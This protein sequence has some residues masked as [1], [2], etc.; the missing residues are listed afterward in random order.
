MYIFWLVGFGV[1]FAVSVVGGVFSC[2]R[3]ISSEM[4]LCVFCGTVFL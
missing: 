2:R 1:R 3:A 4:R